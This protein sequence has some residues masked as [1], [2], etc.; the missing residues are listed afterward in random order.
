MRSSKMVKRVVRYEEIILDS[1][2]KRFARRFAPFVSSLFDFFLRGNAVSKSEL[3]QAKKK[4]FQPFD[5]F[6]AVVPETFTV[7]YQADNTSYG[8]TVFASEASA[9]DYLAGEVAGEP[10]LADELHVIPGFEVTR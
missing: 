6:V 4:Q 2:F 9:R 8:S 3:S 5:D 7:A 1:N 10:N